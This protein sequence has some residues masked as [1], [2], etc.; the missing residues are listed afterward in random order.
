M[1]DQFQPHTNGEVNGEAKGPLRKQLRGYPEKHALQ[2]A[3]SIFRILGMVTRKNKTKEMHRPTSVRRTRA[4][5]LKLFKGTNDRAERTSLTK[6]AKDRDVILKQFLHQGD[7][8]VSL[9]GMGNVASRFVD[10]APPPEREQKGKPPI[11][12]IP[13]ISNDVACVD[14][15][16]QELAYSGR[17]VITIAFPESWMGTIDEQFEKA[18]GESETFAPHA[19]FF[20]NA[21]RQILPRGDMEL[22]G[23]STGGP[24]AAEMLSKDEAFAERVTDAVLLNPAG[25]AQL[26]PTKLWRGVANEARSILT[27]DF[28]LAVLTN[29]RAP[30]EVPEAKGQRGLK[31]AVFGHLLQ[32]VCN[33]SPYWKDAHVKEG[34]SIVVLAGEKDDMTHCRTAFRPGSKPFGNTNITSIA[35]PGTHNSPVLRPVEVIDVVTK[36]QKE[37][38]K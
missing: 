4:K 19:E 2:I 1:S 27:P 23:F 26:N 33:V 15:L 38:Q 8:E 9:N 37:L 31:E 25:S 36:K 28:A 13:G 10:I 6:E 5:I 14:S 24:L 11:V 22:W 30:S 18:V 29:G 16:V 35:F 34:G 32:R 21:I 17:R 20:A 12:L 7:V 3:E